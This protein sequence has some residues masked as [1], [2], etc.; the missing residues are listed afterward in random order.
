MGFHPKRRPHRLSS[1]D[2]R[3]GGANNAFAFLGTRPFTFHAGELRYFTDGSVTTIVGDRDGDGM[4]D[5]QIGTLRLTTL[6]AEDFVL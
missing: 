2:A 6:V 3:T 4:A 1:I 5:F